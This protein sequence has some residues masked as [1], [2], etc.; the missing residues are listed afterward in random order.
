MEGVLIR[1]AE[2]ELLDFS[3]LYA[4]EFS[5]VYRAAWVL[6]R[7][8]EV[9]LEATQEAFA[10]AWARWRRLKDKDWVVG[11][12]ITAA[13][14]EAKDLSRKRPTHIRATNRTAS[15]ADPDLIDLRSALREL[16]ARRRE[17]IVLFYVADLS[18]RSIADVMNL[19]EGT[20]KAHLSQ[21]RAALRGLLEAN[22]E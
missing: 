15:N 16:P 6:A 3:D 8:E 9:A 18:I 21:G 4:G 19:S 10:K 20:V 17:A 7:D 2:R 22:D 13:L 14:N 1:S 11:W 12:V 5:R